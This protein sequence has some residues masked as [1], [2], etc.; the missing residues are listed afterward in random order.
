MGGLEQGRLRYRE[1]AAGER[2][3][4]RGALRYTDAG[5]ADLCKVAAAEG[6]KPGAWA[7]QAAHQAAVRKLRG[8]PFGDG[9][10]HELIAELREGRR[11][12]GNV[13]SSLNQVAKVANSTG[14]VS[15]AAA[16]A[17]MLRVLAR[18]LR[19]HDIMVASIWSRLQR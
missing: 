15:S 12:L 14:R 16:I 2:R 3:A 18:V 4:R 19:A 13:G 1:H 9:Q 7:Q 8:E 5:W 17:T 6:M 10:V 11:V